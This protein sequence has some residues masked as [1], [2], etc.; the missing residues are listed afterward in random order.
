VIWDFDFVRLQLPLAGCK[1]KERP[2]RHYQSR[3]QPAHCPQCEA[4]WILKAARASALRPAAKAATA[5]VAG[6]GTRLVVAR[7]VWSSGPESAL[8]D[9]AADVAE[10]NSVLAGVVVDV[11]SD[12]RAPH[13]PSRCRVPYWQDA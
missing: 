3:M 13:V 10:D 9:A 7:C 8:E 1:K 2:G 12:G 6:T 5:G 11:G 4:D